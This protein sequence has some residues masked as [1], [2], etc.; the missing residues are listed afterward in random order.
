MTRLKLK[1][2]L[3][4]MSLVPVTMCMWGLVALSL[5]EP[6]LTQTIVYGVVGVG[7]LLPGLF[8]KDR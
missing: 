3:L 6:K 5:G 7:F 4:V 1:N 2:F 8:L